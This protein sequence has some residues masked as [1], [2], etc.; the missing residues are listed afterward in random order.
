MNQSYHC[1]K[2]G[3]RKADIDQIRTTGSGFT[4]YFNIQNR[5]F[6]AVICTQCGF[7]EFYRGRPSSGASNVLDFLTN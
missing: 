3:N 2:C 7:T 6:T 1:A 5:R 4:K